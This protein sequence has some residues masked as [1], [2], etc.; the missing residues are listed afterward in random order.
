VTG[1][2]TVTDASWKQSRL[3]PDF[4][5]Y[6]AIIFGREGGRKG[7]IWKT[8]PSYQRS[9]LS[10]FKKCKRMSKLLVLNLIE[11]NLILHSDHSECSLRK[12]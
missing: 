11:L 10:E 3:H 1:T 8:K 9:S 12:E 2:K 6:P 4:L 5:P 7:G